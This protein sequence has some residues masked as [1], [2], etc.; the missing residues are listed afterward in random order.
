MDLLIAETAIESNV[1]LPH[2][3][4]DFDL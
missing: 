2:N 3:D 1:L 4:K